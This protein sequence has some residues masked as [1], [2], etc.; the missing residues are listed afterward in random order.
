MNLR[1]S[2]FM[3]VWLIST[4]AA[5]TGHTVSAAP[6]SSR[7]P[8]VNF[9]SDT[10]GRNNIKIKPFHLDIVAPS[11]GVQFYRNGIIFLSYSKG[12][13]KIPDKHLS[14]GSLKT[15]MAVVMDTVPGSYMPF[16]PSSSKLFP[17]EATT[18]TE[19]YNTMYLSLI[20]DKGSRE[21]I[22]KATLKSNDWVLDREPLNF[23]DGNFIY[24]HPTLSVDGNFMI[25]SSDMPDSNGGLDLYLSKLE[26]GK[27]STPENL[28]NHVNSSGNELFASLD[29]ENNLFFSSDGMPGEGGYD[30]FVCTYNGSGWLKPVNLSKTINS[31][32]D[33]LAFT[34]SRTDKQ[35]AFY[36]SRAKSGKGRMQLFSVTTSLSPD[37][38]SDSELSYQILA[39]AGID[40]REQD[41]KPVNSQP[42][43][44]SVPEKAQQKSPAPGQKAIAKTVEPEKIAAEKKETTSPTQKSS[45]AIDAAAPAQK[46]SAVKETAPPSQKSSAV[47][48]AKAP[49]QKTV[50][51]AKSEEKKDIVVYR[52]QILANTRPVGSQNITVAGKT[53]KSFEYLYQGAYRTT[54]GEFSTM[55]GAGKL[56]NV[57]RQNGY[58][59][60]FVVAFK[61]NIRS[62]DPALFK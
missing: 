26:D 12:D 1:N 62:T 24:S 14:F 11:S 37:K 55:S 10:A 29:T 8:E 49:P 33:E 28:G 57:C 39:L 19:D 18:F 44:M 54:I 53:Y 61:N 46:P 47:T 58:N 36:T 13:E 45:A 16:L 21:K 59:Q 30:I 52:V 7:V 22:F 32:D 34:V 43:A 17:S 9:P 35:S 41:E 56:Q 51:S 31:K 4:V 3:L 25:F 20:P 27:W 15:F 42:V 2:I 40:T 5:F 38:K 48:E 50:A 6:Y 60:A 23:C